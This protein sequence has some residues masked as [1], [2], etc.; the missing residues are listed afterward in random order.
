MPRYAFFALFLVFSFCILKNA[1][2][3]DTPVRSC[4]TP[5]PGKVETDPGKSYCNIYDRQFAYRDENVKFRSD[6]EER[7]ENF[8]AP[9]QKVVHEYQDTLKAR[10]NAIGS[11]S[12]DPAKEPAG[13]PAPDGTGFNP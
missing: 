13:P 9:Q 2:L 4:G 7:R 11:E 10:H 6:I 1:A 3:A 8:G 5:W 12:A